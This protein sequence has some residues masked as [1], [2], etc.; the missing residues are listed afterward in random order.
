MYD[1]S[2]IIQNIQLYV[3]SEEAFLLLMLNLVLLRG[4]KG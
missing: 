2:C 3:C 1:I 4:Y